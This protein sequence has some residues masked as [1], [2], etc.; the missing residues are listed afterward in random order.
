MA[1]S[2]TFQVEVN[3]TPLPDDLAALLVSAYVDSS[4][5]LPDAFMLR[6]RDPNRIVIGKSK[7]KMGAK[8]KITVGSTETQTPEKLIEA[9]VTSLEAETGGPGSFTVIRGYDPAHRLFRGRHTTSYTQ[10]TASDAVSQVAQRAKLPAG[11]IESS[12]TV[13]DH[14]GQFGQTDWEFL[15]GLAKRIGYELTVRDNKLDFRP[16]EPA[17]TAPSDDAQS[18]DPLVLR[19]GTDLLRFRSVI[20]AA[21]QVTEVEVR[22]WD[23]AQKRK[24][25][26]LVPAGTKSVDLPT[27]KP[28]DMAK[29]F[30]DPKYVASDV[31]Y[32]SQSEADTAA[33]ALAEEIGSSFAEIDA[34]AR[35]NP[36]L[37]ANVGIK[38]E[39]AGE[40]FDGKYTITAARHRYDPTHGG[41]TTAFA[42]TGRQERSLYGLTA[43]GSRSAA[44][45]GVVIAQVSDANDPSNQGRVKLTF[46]WL[47]DDY[48]SDWART[49]Q[50]GAGKDRGGMVVPEVGD[51]VLVAFEQQD[52]QRPYVLGGLYNGKDTPIT[53]GPK[54]IDSGSGA[55]NRRSFVSRNGHRI[56]LLDENGKTEGITAE[57]GDGKLKISLDSVGTTIVVHA[58]GRVLI[59]GKK[60]IVIDAATSDL[61]LKGK[62]ISI[63]ATNGLTMSGGAGAVDVDTQTSL[64]LNGTTVKV[65]AKAAAEL[66]AGGP[67]VITGTP[68]KIN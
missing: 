17:T 23:V 8:V 12:K 49:V 16:R 65:A 45:A 47:S 36:K 28:A 27:M 42:V 62:K 40:P 3:G 48:V 25:T 52:P 66:K 50:P 14:L 56:D 61:E 9:E 2:A 60:G 44:G 57:T 13:F 29:P 19:L 58:D 55:V 64:S 4:L 26:S 63:T 15:D 21:E 31:A 39:N 30:G 1:T 34:V 38:V 67:N 37:R 33:S 68:V 54:L 46:P 7:A 35:G 24:I 5:R 11:Q 43:G 20:T 41:Y 10:A 51:E 6:F 59:E 22:G 18:T 53:K 32:R